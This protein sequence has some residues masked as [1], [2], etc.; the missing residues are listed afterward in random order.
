MIEEEQGEEME[1][2]VK[3]LELAVEC[4]YAFYA[5]RELSKRFLNNLSTFSDAPEHVNMTS[6]DLIFYYYY[7]KIIHEYHHMMNVF[8]TS[9][10]FRNLTNFQGEIHSIIHEEKPGCRFLTLRYDIPFQHTSVV[11]RPL[12]EVCGGW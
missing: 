7:E 3:L 5:M 2:M 9:I 11:A 10:F 8:K 12:Q 1:K 6:G 4:K